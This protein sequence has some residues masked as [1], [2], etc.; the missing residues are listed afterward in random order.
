M[1]EAH[2]ALPNEARYGDLRILGLIIPAY[3]QREWQPGSAKNL[4][5]RQPSG[6]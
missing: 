3:L 5:S 2:R 4:A 6:A 1:E